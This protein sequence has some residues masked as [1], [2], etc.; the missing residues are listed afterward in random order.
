[1]NDYAFIFDIDGTLVNL[2]PIWE[3][4]Y[5]ELYQRKYGFSLT[6]Q[7]MK[8]MF[9]PPELEGHS[10]VLKGRKIY[11]T[12]RAEE[13][14]TATERVLVETLGLMD[15]Q[16][17]VLPGVIDTL[18][19]CREQQ[20]GLA[21]ATGNIESIALAILQQAGLRP[22][23][24]AVAYSTPEL[25][26]RQLIVQKAREELRQQGYECLSQNTYVVGDTPSDIKAARA[27]SL[28]VIAVATGNYSV[29]ELAA[30]QPDFLLVD[31]KLFKA[32]F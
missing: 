29:E 2:R 28:P 13:L 7:E 5:H 23:F 1:M 32:M 12:E 8:N 10:N 18:Q 20:Y 21:C 26:S 19:Y 31:L 6:E 17:K 22:F 16:Q 3:R 30:Q 14:V 15:V 25:S 4:T 11:T 24:S 9:G 27:L